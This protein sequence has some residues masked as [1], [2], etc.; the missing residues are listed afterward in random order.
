[1][2]TY[3]AVNRNHSVVPD[4]AS[5]NNTEAAETQSSTNGL[6]RNVSA[7]IEEPSL[8]NLDESKTSKKR[9]CDRIS[10]LWLIRK[11]IAFFKALFGSEEEATDSATAHKC[12]EDNN[13]LVLYANALSSTTHELDRKIRTYINLND[14]LQKIREWFKKCVSRLDQ[15]QIEIA[16]ANESENLKETVTEIEQSLD[17]IKFCIADA[18]TDARNN[19]SETPRKDRAGTGRKKDRTGTGRKK[20][21][22][23][24]VVFNRS[25]YDDFVELRYEKAKEVLQ[26]HKPQLAEIE[27]IREQYKQSADALILNR[28]GNNFTSKMEVVTAKFKYDLLEVIYHFEQ[29]GQRQN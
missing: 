22:P 27:A 8:E 12:Q 25:Y 10:G 1:M 7:V 16:S 5:T 13:P 24:I 6:S 26:D 21:M 19:S 20:D 18:E 11:I 28:N 23:R 29:Q 3:R 17:W 14:N 9:L 2:E 4:G 15:L